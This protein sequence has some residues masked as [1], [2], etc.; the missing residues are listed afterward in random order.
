MLLAGCVITDGPGNDTDESATGG[1]VG[2]A[3]DTGGTAA[4]ETGADGTGGGG[5]VDLGECDPMGGVITEMMTPLPAYYETYCFPQADDSVACSGAMDGDATI[6]HVVFAQTH[7]LEPDWPFF[8]LISDRPALVQVLAT[9]SGP[10]PQVLIAGWIDEQFLGTRCM[11][12]PAALPSS[13]DPETPTANDRFSITLPQTWLQP[14]LR[15]EVRVG[16]ATR[17]FSAD[18]LGIR[19]SSD[20][21]T[22]M[23]NMD[24]LNYNDGMPDKE[25]PATFIPEWAGSL[26]GAKVRF[27]V[28]PDRM[29]FPTFVVGGPEEIIVLDD[30]LCRGDEDPAVDACVLRDDIDDGFVN[31]AALRYIDALIRA[32]GEFPYAFYFGHTQH[33]FPG[34]WGGGKSWVSGDYHDVTLHEG[35]HAASLPHWGNNYGIVPDEWQYLYPYGGEGDYGGGH[36]ERW[37]YHQ[38]IQQFTSPRCEIPDHQYFGTERSDAMQRDRFCLE[39]SNGAQTL[40]DGFSDFS[41]LA[42]Y[43]YLNGAHQIDA[44]DVPYRDGTTAYQLTA[45]GG[46]PSLELDASDNPVLLRYDGF[47]PQG[48]EQRPFSYP[49]QWDVPVHTVYG[50]FAPAMPEANIVYAPMSYTGTLPQVVDPTDSETFDQLQDDGDGLYD[51]DFYWPHDITFRVV[52]TDGNDQIAVHPHSDT[53]R[54]ME[55]GSG[56]WRRDI[57]YMALSVPGDREVSRIEMYHR[58]FV[59]RGANDETEGNIANP[60]FGI[61]AD[62]FLDDAT[63]VASIDL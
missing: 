34:G 62:N 61:T 57:M 25:M 6:E 17:S 63:L 47:E 45:Q 40:W 33:L 13:V 4:D 37:N 51:G 53:Y 9:G 19:H 27:G 59:V 31:A 24:V 29:V 41:A 11:A 50:S 15:L 49:Q 46:F 10:S 54:E 22:A 39:W 5:E 2:D 1:S 21:N 30:R 42:M 23:V 36:G 8:F 7:A 52:Y 26:P 38:N 44:G 32:T 58:P 48:Y 14:G 3:S 20:F 35:G 12:G 56:P 60:M 43:R 18:Q 55:P 16:S 28:F